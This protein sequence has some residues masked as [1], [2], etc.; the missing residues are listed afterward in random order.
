M[1]KVT[2]TKLRVKLFDLLTAVE[3]GETVSVQKGGRIVALIVP[4]GRIDWRDG[5]TV[6]PKLLVSADRAFAPLDEI[7]EDYR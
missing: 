4:A 1:L 5:I 2:A 7:W 6:R 3:S